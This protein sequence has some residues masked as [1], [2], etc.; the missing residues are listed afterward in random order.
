[1]VESLGF[2]GVMVWGSGFVDAAAKHGRAADMDRGRG[3][4]GP[5]SALPTSC[6]STECFKGLSLHQ[7]LT[8]M[9][10]CFY[11]TLRFAP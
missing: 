9:Y 7:N 5:K 10:M 3:V 8:T 6:L 2:R 4:M 1:M 11:L